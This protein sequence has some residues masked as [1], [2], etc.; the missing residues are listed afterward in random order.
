MESSEKDN[1][2]SKQYLKQICIEK[3]DQNCDKYINHVFTSV[4]FILI[5]FW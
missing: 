4:Q 5:E 1:G 2:K 3:T